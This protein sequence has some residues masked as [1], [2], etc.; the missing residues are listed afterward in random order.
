[1]KQSVW[2]LLTVSLML[3]VV[4]FTLQ[5]SEVATIKVFVWETRASLSLILISTFSLG[6]LATGAYFMPSLINLRV[7]LNKA[8]KKIAKLEAD[9][10]NS[11]LDS[12][13]PN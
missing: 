1:M 12:K 9:K 13:Q 6:I 5:N 4:V 11:E 8:K 2:L 3:V 10:G 7:S